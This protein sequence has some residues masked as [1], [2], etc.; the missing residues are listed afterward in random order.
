MLGPMAMQRSGWLV[1]LAAVGGVL[2]C[3]VLPAGTSANGAAQ[4]QRVGHVWTIASDLDIG[5]GGLELGRDGSL[6]VSDFGTRLS[7]GV[8]GTRVLRIRPNGAVETFATGF[9]GATGSVLLDDGRFVQA[10]IASH[11]LS[12]V[13]PGGK[14]TPFVTEGLRGPVGIA[15]GSAGDFFVANCGSDTVSHVTSTGQVRLFAEGPLFRC[16]N[17]IVRAADGDLYVSNFYNG[18]VIRVKPDGISE[19]LVTLPGNNNGHLTAGADVLYVAGR[20][21]N[22]I[23]EVGLTGS[24]RVIAGS[25]VRGQTDG[26]AAMATLSLPNDLALSVDGRTLYFNEVGSVG[27]DDQVLTPTTVRALR[28]R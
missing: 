3:M 13:T 17:G 8:P 11:S 15:R 6:Y 4:G 5:T 22:Q 19:R 18:D 27:P 20:K 12:I 2:A 28:L 21:A 1:R 7:G 24:F 14:V 26:A 23:F 25:G 16:P 9:R 10:N